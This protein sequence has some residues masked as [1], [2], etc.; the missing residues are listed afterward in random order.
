MA[1]P[2]W[3]SGVPRQWRREP[4]AAYWE[5][6]HAWELG[7]MEEA[8]QRLRGETWMTSADPEDAAMREAMARDTRETA[9]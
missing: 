1:R 4:Q 8:R 7:R 9:G 5:R 6:L 2:A 3:K